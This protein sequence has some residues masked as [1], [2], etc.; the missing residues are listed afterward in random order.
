[1]SPLVGLQHYIDGGQARS[2][3]RDG[4]ITGQVPERFGSPRVG[5]VSTDAVPTLQAGRI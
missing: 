4:L 2:D 3:Q 5:G 1:M